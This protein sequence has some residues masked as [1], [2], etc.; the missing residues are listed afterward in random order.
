[1]FA[2]SFSYYLISSP[3][4]S[5]ISF[6]HHLVS[7]VRP[8]VNFDIFIFHLKT[9]RPNGTKHYRKHLW[10]VLYRVGSFCPDRKKKKPSWKVLFFICYNIKKI[11]SYESACSNGTIFNRKHL[12]NVL[13]KVFS[14]CPDSKKNL[15]TMDDSC[16]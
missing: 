10:K 12:Y 2:F 11:F 8:S 13:Y 6:C 5:H 4:Q 15:A 16:F 14:S 1:M 7:V 3:G 9:A